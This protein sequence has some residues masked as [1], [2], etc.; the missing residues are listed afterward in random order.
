MFL[1]T[2]DR[3][4]SN[5]IVDLRLNPKVFNSVFTWFSN[6]PRFYFLISIIYHAVALKFRNYKLFSD[7][8]L[9]NNCINLDYIN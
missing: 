9:I 4:I 8:Y 5:P 2:T 6:R 7:R 1:I 3:K